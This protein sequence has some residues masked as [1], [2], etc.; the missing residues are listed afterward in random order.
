MTQPAPLSALLKKEADTWVLQCLDFDVAVQAGNIP[1]LVK[2]LERVLNG[3]ILLDLQAGRQPLENV[4]PAPEADWE[5]FR[6]AI[7]KSEDGLKLRLIE[8]VSARSR[9]HAKPSKTNKPKRKAAAIPAP[10]VVRSVVSE[11]RVA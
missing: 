3:H 2:E 1:D 8:P 10:W 7:F 11:V 5:A 4:P 9:P 6:S